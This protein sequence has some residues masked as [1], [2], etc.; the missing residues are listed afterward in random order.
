VVAWAGDWG[1]VMIG[2]ILLGG[3]RFALCCFQY[4]HIQACFFALC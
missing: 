1:G 2:A 4:I 3:W